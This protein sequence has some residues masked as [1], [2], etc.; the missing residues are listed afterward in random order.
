[1][2]KSRKVSR[3]TSAFAIAALAA[4]TLVPISSRASLIGDTATCSITPSTSW[5]CSAPSFTIVAG[6]DVNL[7]LLGTPFFAV[8]F[9]ASSV[10]LTYNG[11]YGSPFLLGASEDA[12]FGNLDWVG[13][14]ST[15]ITGFSLSTNSLV[16]GIDASH[17]SFTDHSLS[18]NLDNGA[19]Y[20]AGAAITV[21]LQT[22]QV[23][24]PSAL[25]LV[26]LG[27]AGLGFWRRK[28]A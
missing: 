28:K 22:G 9:G 21:G 16:T 15:V 5:A 4:L 6:P 10:T 12:T 25:A 7:N 14:P 1:M 19:S 23:D 27:L 20:S 24:E 13:A 18:I 8:D 26:A 17:V 2:K 3:L 11:S